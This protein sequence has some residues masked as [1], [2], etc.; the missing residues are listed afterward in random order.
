MSALDRASKAEIVLQNPIYQEAFKQVRE[1]LINGIEACPMAD[2]QTAEDFRRC[3][4]LLSKV[5]ANL[6]LAIQQGKFEAFQ[7]EQEKKRKDNPCRGI[8][9]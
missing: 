2:T 7:L 9:R 8:F 6:E 5:Q 3:L 1:S 4:K